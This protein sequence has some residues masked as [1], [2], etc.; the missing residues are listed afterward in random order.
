VA[1]D[2]P[3]DPRTPFGQRV[4]RR[5]EE[6]LVVWLTT[7]GSDLTPQPNPVWFL[8]EGDSLLVYNAAGA[9]RLEH[10]RTRPRVS[11]NFEGDRRGGDIIVI[12]ATARVSEQEPPP[13][14]HAAYVAKY[15]RRME[16]VSGSL[17]KFSREYPVPL[18][19]RP[20][21]VRGF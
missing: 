3:P 19:I 7:V 13:H 2:F 11:V 17:E 9:R 18:R 8:W 5:L 6:D 16:G 14:Q 20:L 4:H 15:G 12:T 10:V 1:A 21:R